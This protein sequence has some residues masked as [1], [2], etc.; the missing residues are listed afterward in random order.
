VPAFRSVGFVEWLGTAL[1]KSLTGAAASNAQRYIFL[2]AALAS[3]LLAAF[4]LTLPHTPPRPSG[5]EPLAWLKAVKLLKHPFILILFVVTFVDSAVHGSFFYWTASFLKTEVGIPAN[6]VGPVMKIGQVAEIVTMLVLGA[7][8]KTLGWRLT[9]TIGVLG[10]AARFAVFTYYPEQTPVIA[11]NVLHGVCY[12]FF[13]ATVYI[14]VD[15]YFPKDIRSSAQGLFNV[16]ILGIGPFTA[17]FVC[18]R[19]KEA[20]SVNGTVD[21]PAV[22]KYSMGASLIAGIVLFVF[23]HPKM[24]PKDPPM[25]SAEE[26]A[27]PTP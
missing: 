22:F 1:D 3:F 6:W 27:P 15:E 2:V 16:L 11:I 10:Y 7:V 25:F 12:A 18:G 13:F 26:D 8:L 19:L 24:P 20:H 21:Y 9:M 17:N 4:S 14:F 23:F 5:G